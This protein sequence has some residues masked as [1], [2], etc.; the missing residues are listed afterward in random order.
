MSYSEKRSIVS[1]FAGIAVLV[2]YGIYVCGKVRA[3]MAAPDDLKF[4]AGAMLLFII[5]GIAANIVIQIVFHILLSM[6]IAIREEV[7]TGHSDDKQIEKKI[8]AEIIEDEMDKLIELKSLRVGF[9]VAGAGFV[10][11]LIFAYLGSSIDIMMN[12]IFFSFSGGS[13]I[14]GFSQIFFYRRGVTRG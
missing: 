1:I 4:W 9:A 13:I 14:E 8:A 12:I 10:T 2:S 5:I 3:G 7:K 11:A 6:S